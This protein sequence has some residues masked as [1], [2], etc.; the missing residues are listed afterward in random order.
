MENVSV[1]IRRYCLIGHPVAHSVSPLIHGR[2]F[3]ALKIPASYTLVDT[4]GRDLAEVV[5]NLKNE[6]FLG[7][8]VTMPDK[9]AMCTMCDSLSEEAQIAQAVN[10]VICDHGRLTGTTTDGEGF[11]CAAKE[12]GVTLAG[13]RL[14]LLG[15]GGAASAIL[16]ASALAGAEAIDVFV[17][18]NSSR[19]RVESIA[20]RLRGKCTCPITIRDFSDTESLRAA[21]AGCVLLANATPVGMGTQEGLSPLPDPGLLV[22]SAAVFDAIYAP[23]KT[24]LLS[25]AEKAGCRTANGLSMLIGQAAASF[26][27][28]TGREMPPISSDLF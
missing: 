2:A 23:R 18:S 25:D 10:T 7:W 9:T 14:V 28:W 27:L 20:S 16:I 24:A 6:G 5:R 22:P 21:I 1:S 13:N 19:A 4:G 26:R 8:N 15:G 17:R 3:A 11:L 12:L